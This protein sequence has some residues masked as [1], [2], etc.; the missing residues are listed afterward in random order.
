MGKKE[1]DWSP[2]GIVNDPVLKPQADFTE[3]LL[4]DYKWFDAKNITPRFE[5]GFGLSYS[6]FSFG[7]ASVSKSFKKDH[8][9][10]QPTSEKFADD[11][12][13]GESVYDQVLE[14]EVDVTNSGKVDAAEVAQLYVQVSLLRS[15]SFC[16]TLQVKD[17]FH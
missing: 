17:P 10:I 11:E 9:S 8:T 5:F 12:F 4:V 13:D 1:S 16:P 3:K 7:E 15:C 2:N 14:V 6:T